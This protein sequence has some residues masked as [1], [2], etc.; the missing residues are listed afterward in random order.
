MPDGAAL[1]GVE[2]VNAVMG[3]HIASDLLAWVRDIVGGR[4]RSYEQTLE[5]AQSAAMQMLH[6][7]CRARGA[8]HAAG[9]RMDCEGLG[10]RSALIAVIITATLYRA[11]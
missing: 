4:R 6:Q 8:T 2:T 9:L 1:L 10:P 11:R 3:T 5:Q 7:R